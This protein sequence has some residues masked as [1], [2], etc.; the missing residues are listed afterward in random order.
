MTYDVRDLPGVW[1]SADDGSLLALEEGGDFRLTS[2]GDSPVTAGQRVNVASLGGKWT[3]ADGQ[4]RL[5]ADLRSVKF[6]SPSRL[7]AIGL[8]MT[9]FLLRFARQK[10]IVDGRITHLT[11][12]DL[13]VEDAQGEVAKFQKQ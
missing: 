8:A 7:K 1:V 2:A 3:V 10:E 12:T 13:W 5:T 4:L 9:S 6:S 11:G